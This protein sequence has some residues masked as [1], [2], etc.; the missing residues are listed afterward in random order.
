LQ[1]FIIEEQD[2]IRNIIETTAVFL[3]PRQRIGVFQVLV[4]IKFTHG[5]ISNRDFG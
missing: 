4:H 5:V 1:L 3:V 2:A